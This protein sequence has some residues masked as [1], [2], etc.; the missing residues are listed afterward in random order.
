MCQFGY[1]QQ[2]RR[3]WRTIPVCRSGA[4][5]GIVIGVGRAGSLHGDTVLLTLGATLISIGVIAI[6]SASIEYGDFH[7]GNPWH[8]T[9]RHAA[10]LMLAITLGALAYMAPAASVQRLSPWLLFLAV[11]LLILVMI[12]GI[13]REV[14]GAQRWLPLGVIT[15]QPSEFAK[16]AVLLYAAGYLVRQEDAVRHHWSGLAKLIA[17][18]SVVAALLLLEPDFGATVIIVGV[19]VGMTFLAGAKLVYVLAMLAAAAMALAFLV[20]SA[21]Y[22]MKRLT[23]YQDPWADP[24]GSGF[25]LV[26]SLIAFGQGEWWGVGLGNSVQK[27]FYLPEAHTDFVFSIWSEETGLI[28]ATAMIALFV[29]L[30]ARVLNIGW[31]AAAQQRLFEAYV[32][33]GAA[34]MF[35]GQAFVNMGAS[36]GLLPTKGLTLPFVSY[37][38]N[39]LIVNC[40]LL[41]M[42]LRAAGSPES[43]R[44]ESVSALKRVKA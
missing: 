25:Q 9:Q 7:F 41:G 11:A 40:M 13:G 1:V 18:L 31:R 21:P 5:G 29:M 12:P 19:V 37:G 35:A 8:H 20:L 36:S 30:I 33:F 28:G 23:A 14:N 16:L 44:P 2:L 15:L 42:V 3:T 17:I 43:E 10:Y 32:C 39:S 27:L 26:Q 24:F 4:G 22:R 6:A 38:G 34:L